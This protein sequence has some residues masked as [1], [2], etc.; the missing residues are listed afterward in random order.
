MTPLIILWLLKNY[1]QAKQ[2][3]RQLA[4]AKITKFM[5]LVTFLSLSIR[6]QE[7]TLC[8]NVMHNGEKKGRLLLY[9]NID[10]NKV[11]IKIESEVKARFIFLITVKSIE[12]AIFQDGIL[13]FSSICRKVNNDERINQQLH[14]QHDCY[15]IISKNK[16]TNLAAY[17]IK[18]STLSLYYQEP[19]N[20]NQLFADSFRQYV[21]IKKVD[22][23]KYKVCLPNGSN[24]YTYKNGVCIK[25]EA[26]QSLYPVQFIL[27]Q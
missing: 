2:K 25:V 9:Q 8:Y 11:H 23:N 26:E 13:I 6:A 19:V 21:E 15:S 10:G 20:I 17:P 1:R 5:F 18:Y 14:A 27:E 4:S 16:K 22:T 3:A 24:Y 7:K 12:E